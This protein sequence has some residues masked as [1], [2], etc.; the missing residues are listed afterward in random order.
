MLYRI[1]LE[2]L[3]SLLDFFLALLIGA[4]LHEIVQPVHQLLMLV[5]DLLDADIIRFPPSNHC[6]GDSSPQPKFRTYRHYFT[7]FI[8]F[9]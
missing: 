8:Y 5:I 2:K 3:K 9:P 4:G 6:L 7:Y 1:S